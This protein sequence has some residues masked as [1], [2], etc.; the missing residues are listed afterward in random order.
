MVEIPPAFRTID[1]EYK[2]DKSLRFMA[3][4]PGLNDRTIWQK[5]AWRLWHAPT[6]K[7]YVEQCTEDG[8]LDKIRQKWMRSPKQ[9]NL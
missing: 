3:C 1:Q 7:L 8:T 9:E 6:F 5:L 2:P 4:L